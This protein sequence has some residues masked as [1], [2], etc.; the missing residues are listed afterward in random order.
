MI[1]ICLEETLFVER[2]SKKALK[3]VKFS[4]AAKNLKTLILSTKLCVLWRMWACWWPHVQ[5]GMCS[6]DISI[7]T[8]IFKKYWNSSVTSW[9]YHFHTHP[10]EGKQHAYMAA[11]VFL[12][13]VATQLRWGGILW[14]HIGAMIFRILC[15]KNY[16]HCFKLH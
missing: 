3:H 10:P 13:S 2:I 16:K 4:E 7:S 1:C 15:I 5:S 9:S 8:W 6:T 11:N 14:F 12:G